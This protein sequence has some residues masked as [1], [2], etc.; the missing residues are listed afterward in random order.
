MRLHHIDHL[1]C[2]ENMYNFES[3]L[4]LQRRHRFMNLVSR[5]TDFDEKS[6][7]HIGQE[8]CSKNFV[9]GMVSQIRT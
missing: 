7:L 6:G 5:A 3:V 8:F 2:N 9:E 1:N 4:E